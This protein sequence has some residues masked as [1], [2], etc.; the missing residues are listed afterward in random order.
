M[1]QNRFH[2]KFIHWNFDYSWTKSKRLYLSN[3]HLALCKYEKWSAHLLVRHACYRIQSVSGVVRRAQL[4]ADS[5]IVSKLAAVT[6][7]VDQVKRFGTELKTTLLN[8]RGGSM[9]HELSSEKI[10]QILKSFAVSQSYG[11]ASR[12]IVS[13]FLKLPRDDIV[14]R[15]FSFVVDTSSTLC[16]N[17]QASKCCLRIQDAEFTRRDAFISFNSLLLASHYRNKG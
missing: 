1:L 17:V 16:S 10:R 7:P 5:E 11:E 9:L 14:Q 15:A 6:S 2:C 3:I 4:H 12:R 13:I 8:E